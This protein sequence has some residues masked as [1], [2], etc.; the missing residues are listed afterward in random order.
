M[1]VVG[2]SLG[3]QALNTAIPQALALIPTDKRPAVTHQAGQAHVESLT[4]NYRNAG[5]EAHCV[6]FIDD[7]A[8][9]LRHADLVICRAGAMTVAEVSAVGTAALF[10]PFPF[11]VDDHQTGNAQFL[12]SQQAAWMK[13]QKDLTPQWLSE[14]MLSLDRGQLCTVATKALALAKPDATLHIAQVLEE[15]AKP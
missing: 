13:Q 7:M 6:A 10:I 5:V 12:V 9:A 1:L 4:Q 8:A 3:A 15:V 2:G 14:W 11:A